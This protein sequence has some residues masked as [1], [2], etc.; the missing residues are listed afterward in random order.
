MLTKDNLKTISALPNRLW[1]RL[2][3]F[4]LVCIPLLFYFN[5]QSSILTK[6]IGDD[7]AIFSA[8][9]YGWLHG[10]IPYLEM[11]D[12]K[13]PYLFFINMVAHAMHIGKWAIWLLE[14]G[15]AL[16]VFEIIY[17]IGLIFRLSTGFNYLACLICAG[18]YFACIYTGSS[19]E[20][21]SLPFQ[22]GSLLIALKI[23]SGQSH[24]LRKS[25]FITGLCFG[26][27]AFIRINNNCTICGIVPALIIYLVQKK[28][29]KEIW[30]SAVC[31]IAG[32]ALAAAPPILYFAYYG[33][34][35]DMFYGTFG[36]NMTYS[37]AQGISHFDTGLF[38]SPCFILPFISFYYDRKNKSNFFVISTLISLITFLSLFFILF[39]NHYYL[40]LVPVVCLGAQQASAFKWPVRAIALLYLLIIP[41]IA[42]HEYRYNYN[43][44]K[45]IF[46]DEAKTPFIYPLTSGIIEVIPAEDLDSVY[47]YGHYPLMP[48][49]ELGHLPAGKYFIIQFWHSWKVPDIETDIIEDF[50]KTNP[51]WILSQTEFAA[52]FNN[53]LPKVLDN[54]VEIPLDSLP[55]VFA[56]KKV[57]V[58]RR[59]DVQRVRKN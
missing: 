24:N 40:L 34:L 25:A 19:S 54:Y 16:F 31:F 3:V 50:Y 48:L 29:Y 39:S 15:I 9:G 26:I 55:P 52:G 22:M 41:Y 14:L 13:G 57:N 10:R 33:A 46:E 23:I 12:H 20:E 8:I 37:F 11:F 47:N 49:F 42:R 56:E 36:F 51:R 27:V 28:Q 18:T 32:V 53:F 30:E 59:K 43:R 4:A 2:L 7:Y 35:G 21:M 45:E 5:F 44:I 58:F 17:R 6:S 1:V 38:L